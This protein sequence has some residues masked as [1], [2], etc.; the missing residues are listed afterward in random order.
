VLPLRK[1][2]DLRYGENHHQKGAFYDDALGI[3]GTE[4][5]ISTHSQLHGKSLSYNNI[6][7]A[8]TAV[9]TLKEFTA[10]TVV[11]IKHATPSG[12]ASADDLVQAWKDAYATDTYSP[13]GGVVAVNR[14]VTPELADELSAVFLEVILAPSFEEEALARLRKKKNIRLLAVAG[15]DEG[16]LHQGLTLRSVTGGILVQERDARA[17]D[18]GQWRTVTKT[19]PSKGQ[20]ASLAFAAACVKHVRSNA[21]VFATGTRTVGIGG[22]QTARVDA[23]YIATKK[24][25]ANI[26]GSVL[27]SDAFFPFRDT[28][29]AAAKAG[30]AAIVQ[31]GGSIRDKE[32]IEA[33]D[34][35]GIAMVF[36]D[37]RS[38][39]H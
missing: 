23:V 13:F 25:A 33:A 17:I 16:G 20:L 14:P 11:I 18:P 38:F 24:G 8:D 29:D 10:P 35:H 37:H 39:R 27:A 4:P 28:V 32:V 36:S 7:D 31:P 30:V 15:L 12:S 2:A 22:G 21:V 34:E 5:S 1:R 3:L 26:K 19:K 9:E 6:L